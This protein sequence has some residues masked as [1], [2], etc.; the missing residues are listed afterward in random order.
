MTT[1]DST[2]KLF[3]AGANG[4]LGEADPAYAHNGGRFGGYTAAV[5]LRAAM[6]EDGERGDPLSLTILFTDAV[7]DGPFEVS[8]R[9]LRAGSRLQFWRSELS[10]RGKLCAHAQATFGVKRPTTRFTDAVMPDA[11]SADSA[12]L[13]E[14]T[15]PVPF[16]QQFSARWATPSPLLSATDGPARS[17]FWIRDIQGRALDHVLLAAMADFA[18]PRVMYHTKRF[19]M[20]STVSMTVHFHAT[21]DEL[22]E[23]GGDYVLSEVECRRCEGGYFDHELRLWSKS[24]ALLA[25][26]EQVAA[27]RD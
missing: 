3:P 5:L 20:S 17:V 9:L 25:T 22:A 8:T 18:P 4:W 1:F 13:V 26:S 2:I 16:G 15:P 23:V 14:S 12:G 24:G 21:A 10:Q 6:L 7:L 19:V 11:P 27:F